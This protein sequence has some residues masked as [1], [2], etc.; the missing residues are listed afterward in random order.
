M[1]HEHI[2]DHQ[3]ECCIVERSEAG[4]ATA[5]RKPWALSQTLMACP[6]CKSSSPTRMRRIAVSFRLSLR[7]H[8]PHI[9]CVEFSD[10]NHCVNLIPAANATACLP[11]NVYKARDTPHRLAQL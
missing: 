10:A 2:H 1:R 5:T 11:P 3:I 8:N 7:S 4:R 9:D 6:T